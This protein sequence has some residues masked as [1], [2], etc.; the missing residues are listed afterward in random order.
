MAFNSSTADW[1]DLSSG[2]VITPPT[3][4][5]SVYNF[6]PV[7]IAAFPDIGN[8]NDIREV[9]QGLCEQ[10]Y[11]AQ[12]AQAALPI[13]NISTKMNI[14]KSI[15]VNASTNENTIFYSMSFVCSGPTTNTVAPEPT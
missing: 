6:F 7:D 13:P 5:A 3:T 4:Y 12:K 2:I 14:Q 8:I 10:M 1:I 9:Y 11:Q 15:S